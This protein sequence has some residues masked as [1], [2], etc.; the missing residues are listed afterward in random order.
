[1]ERSFW[2]YAAYVAS[3][4]SSV[5]PV[6]AKEFV[7]VSAAEDGVIERYEMNPGTG[8]LTPLGRTQAGKLVM[9]LAI[10]VRPRSHADR[11]IRLTRIMTAAA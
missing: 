8:A 11:A 3:T 4:L 5:S 2:L 7:Y 9:P 6:M 10:R 1:M